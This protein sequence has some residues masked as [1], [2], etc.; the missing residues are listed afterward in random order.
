MPATVALAQAVAASAEATRSKLA[1]S[2]CEIDLHE[3]RTAAT[4]LRSVLQSAI[5]ALDS[6]AMADERPT[7]RRQGS[8]RH[9]GDHWEIGLEGR[10]V[11]VRDSKGL[12]NLRELLS[13]PGVSVSVADLANIVIER[14]VGPAF[15]ER[16]RREIEDRIRS[17]QE[18]IDEASAANDRGHR[19]WAENEL[20]VLVS[21]LSAA[22]GLGGRTRPQAD[23]IERARSTVTARIRGSIKR[24]YD[25]DAALA[26]HLDICISTGRMC[27]YSPDALVEWTF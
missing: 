3:A 13:Q 14:D 11:T 6:V 26:R 4:H 19:E 2:G 8:W 22:Y 21:E 18:T 17:C 5:R 23:S 25:L 16:A 1:H 20:D 27:Q 10:R 7:G 9:V 15:D 12:R 24:I